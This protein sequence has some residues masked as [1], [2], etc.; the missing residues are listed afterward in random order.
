MVDSPEQSLQPLT[1][2]EQDRHTAAQ[3]RIDVVRETT[4]SIIAVVTVCAVL[5]AA[6]R[7]AVGGDMVFAAFLFLTNVAMTVVGFYFGSKNHER[8]GGTGFSQ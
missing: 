8:T 6:V 4:Q 7:L 5:Y 1:T 2:S 3:R